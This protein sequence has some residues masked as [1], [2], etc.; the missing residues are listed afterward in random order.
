MGAGLGGEALGP[1][2]ALVRA[3]FGGGTLEA[4]V[5]LVRLGGVDSLL[6][7]P[8]VLLGVMLGVLAMEEG[9]SGCLYLWMLDS[10]L[11]VVV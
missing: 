11:L 1:R 4:L 5:S 9:S 6:L 3:G 8:W 10:R 2:V 7:V